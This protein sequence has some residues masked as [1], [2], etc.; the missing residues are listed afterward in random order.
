MQKHFL[1]FR[2][3]CTNVFFSP[4]ILIS[5]NSELFAK[6]LA[7]DV[8]QSINSL[9]IQNLKNGFFRGLILKKRKILLLQKII[10]ILMM[11]VFLSQK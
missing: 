2:K 6:N 11:E 9:E 10:M 8:E 4:L 3:V 5:N 7:N 1:K